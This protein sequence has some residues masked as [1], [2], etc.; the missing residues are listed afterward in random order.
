MLQV[1]K[2]LDLKG[3]EMIFRRSEKE[4]KNNN[5]Q[6]W[7]ISGEEK[8]EKK[9]LFWEHNTKNYDET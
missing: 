8:N 9:Y 1:W 3:W 5:P 2:D 6:D 4:K 7:N